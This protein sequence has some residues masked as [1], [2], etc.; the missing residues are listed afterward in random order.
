MENTYT[1]AK[2]TI[3]KRSFEEIKKKLKAAGYEQAFLAGNIINMTGIGL[4][5]ETGKTPKK[6]L[7]LG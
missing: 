4:L 7:L 6:K 1:L 2:L 3:S 5:Q